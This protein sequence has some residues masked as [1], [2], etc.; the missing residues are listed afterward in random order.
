MK[1]ARVARAAGIDMRV[2]APGLIP[3]KPTDR[4]KT[5]ARDAE[6]LVRQLAAGAPVVRS[7]PERARGGVA[8]SRP[9]PRGRPPR[10]HASAASPEQDAAARGLR[11]DAGKPGRDR[12]IDWIVRLKFDDLASRDRRRRVHQ[13]RPATA[14]SA[15]RISSKPSSSCCR[16]RRLP[17]RLPPALLPRPGDPL[18]GRPVLRDRRLRSLRQTRRNWRRSWSSHRVHTDTK[19]RLGAITKAGSATPAAALSKHRGRQRSH[20]QHHHLTNVTPYQTGPV[21]P[22]PAEA[23]A[24]DAMN[25]SRRWLVYYSRDRRPHITSPAPTSRRL[26][27]SCSGSRAR[28]A[29]RPTLAGREHAAPSLRRGQPRNALHGSCASR[30]KMISGV[31]SVIVT[32]AIPGAGCSRI[33]YRANRPCARARA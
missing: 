24:N 17:H 7:C 19:R 28:P 4:I 18:R 11:Y 27:R 8:R 23:H 6:R 21:R 3:R 10:P 30:A 33:T 14:L 12:H 20:H 32:G 15:A 9:R 5:D 13:R 2:C 22:P 25:R 31:G 1:L 26:L 29:R 16:Q